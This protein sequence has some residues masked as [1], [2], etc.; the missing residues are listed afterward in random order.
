MT[1]SQSPA[2]AKK[3][4]LITSDDFGM[5]HAINVGIVRGM[6][7]GVVT[8]T[9][10][11]APCP[12]FPEAARLA[13]QH[14]LKAGVHLC[15]TCDWDNMRWG[16]IT[17]AKSLCD[18]NGY[19]FNS[20]PEVGRRA[21]PRELVDELN[22]QVARV[23]A[24]GI[25][26]THIDI[27]MLSGDDSREG[28]DKLRA[29]VLEVARQHGLIY[30]RE[31]NADGSLKYLTDQTGSSGA[32]ERDIWQRLQAWTAPGYYNIVAH[33]AVSHPEL[34]DLSSENHGAR[35]WASPYRVGDFAFVMKAATRGRIAELGF[36]LIDVPTFLAQKK[37]A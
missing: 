16:P 24:F 17:K 7:E 34:E 1:S 29:G 3:Y 4:L 15:M 30:T 36:E 14:K 13:K 37:L 27:H 2:A 5:C 26:P 25:D 32:S 23:K 35:N 9:N 28:C 18:E 33:V 22:A 8:S 21:D 19:F 11:M 20:I 31:C 10:L 6:T 12:W